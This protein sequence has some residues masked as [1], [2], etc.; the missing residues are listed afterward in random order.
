MAIIAAG[1][2]PSSA[3]LFTGNHDLEFNFASWG[4]F[5]EL[6][7]HFGVVV[8]YEP[9]T[10]FGLDGLPLFQAE[11]WREL[12]PPALYTPVTDQ[13]A[14]VEQVLCV[15]TL[16]ILAATTTLLEAE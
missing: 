2:F 4:Y 10:K 6:L 13:L 15:L 1:G 11:C 9:S 7:D 8:R 14:G 3:T 16:I 5:F 12:P